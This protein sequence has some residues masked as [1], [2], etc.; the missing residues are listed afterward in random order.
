[1]LPFILA[2]FLAV[3]YLGNDDGPLDQYFHGG[4]IRDFYSIASYRTRE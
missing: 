1:M 2:N 4:M 3:W